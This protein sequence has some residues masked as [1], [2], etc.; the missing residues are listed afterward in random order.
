MME[1]RLRGGSNA[2]DRGLLMAQGHGQD[3]DEHGLGW[4]TMDVGSKKLGLACGAACTD[5]LVEGLGGT[6]GHWRGICGV[7]VRDMF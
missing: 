5:A 4:E 2:S 3:Q 1:R 7:P 6:G